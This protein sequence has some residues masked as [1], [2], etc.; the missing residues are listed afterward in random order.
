MSA[1]KH[2]KRPVALSV[3]EAGRIYRRPRSDG[4]G[5]DSFAW[6]PSPAKSPEPARQRVYGLIEETGVG[7]ETKKEA[8][9]PDPPSRS[10]KPK[11][12]GFYSSRIFSGQHNLE[13]RDSRE[14]ASAGL[15]YED[16]SLNDLRCWTATLGF[17]Y[18]MAHT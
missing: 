9:V 12:G 8:G 4:A 13:I 14:Y 2:I 18:P 3:K 16:T 10:R 11:K 7:F 1:G 15:F 6:R 5:R 17:N